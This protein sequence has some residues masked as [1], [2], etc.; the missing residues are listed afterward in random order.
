MHTHTQL[1]TDT[2]TPTFII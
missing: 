2:F 1:S